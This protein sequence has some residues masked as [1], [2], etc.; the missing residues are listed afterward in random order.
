MTKENFVNENKPVK[1]DFKLARLIVKKYGLKSKV[2]LSKRSGT[3]T[4]D[5]SVEYDTIELRKEYENGILNEN[6]AFDMKIIH[7]LKLPS[8]AL[9]EQKIL[10]PSGWRMSPSKT[11]HRRS[12]ITLILFFSAY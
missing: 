3:S 6:S 1:T 11:I 9:I 7:Y 4:G 5:Y 8:L 10:G 12:Y 2:V